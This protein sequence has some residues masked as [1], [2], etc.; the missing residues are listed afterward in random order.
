MKKPTVT[1]LKA[2]ADKLFSEYIRRRFAEFDG[3]V[4][5]FT[6]GV[7]KHWKEQ[8]A[9]HFASRRHM[10]TRFDYK[11]VQV[12]CQACNIWNQGQ[13]WKFGQYLDLTYGH[14]TA[15][16]LMQ[17]SKEINKMSRIDYEILIEEIKEK[18]SELD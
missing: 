8:Q 13:Q 14:G 6:C 15:E 10:S 11:N 1:K 18:L 7:K 17:K 3:F 5:C 16:E 2:K 4:S 9:G 12:Q